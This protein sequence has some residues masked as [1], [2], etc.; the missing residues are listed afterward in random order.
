MANST[1][2]PSDI[3]FKEIG[4]NLHRLLKLLDEMDFALYNTRN[5]YEALSKA[6]EN[7]RLKARE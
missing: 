6:Y 1:I 7:A 5:T 3:F 4:Y 2:D